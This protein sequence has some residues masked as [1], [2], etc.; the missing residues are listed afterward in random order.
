MAFRDFLECIQEMRALHALLLRHNGL[1]DSFADELVFLV[2]RSRISTLDI[3]HN[4]LGP[5]GI[6]PMFEAMKVA[7]RMRWIK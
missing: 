4:D 7:Q 5:R 3:S 6:E 2:Q 1:D